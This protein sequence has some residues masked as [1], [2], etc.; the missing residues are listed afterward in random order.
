M[1]KR[2]E[3]NGYNL[4][5][6]WFNYKFENQGVLKPVD[7]EL[8][9]YIVDKWNRLGQIDV[10]GLPTD[11]TMQALEIGS[12]KTYKKA[13]DR[14]IENNF[15]IEITKSKN[16]HLSRKI[17]LVKNTNEDTKAFDKANIN[18]HTNES[19]NESAVIDKQL[20]NQTIKQLKRE[21]FAPPKF[22]EVEQFVNDKNYQ[23]VNPDKFWNYYESNGWMV[24]KNKMKDWK[25]A[26]RK[27]SATDNNAN[28][29]NSKH[30]KNEREELTV[31]RQ[32]IDSATKNSNGFG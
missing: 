17:A 23:N 25:A 8:Y 2:N 22:Y 18:A 28:L 31:N 24:G 13:L 14:L 5:R 15:I 6:N 11:F 7:A 19:T 12:Y 16:I 4:T 1:S 26:I 32:T 27:W 20:N 10:M 29:N 21:R 9:F 3:M 30:N